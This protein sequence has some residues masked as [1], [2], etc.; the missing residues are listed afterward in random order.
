MKLKSNLPQYLRCSTLE[1]GLAVAQM[2]KAQGWKLY[3]NCDVTLLDE[4]RPFVF[5]IK[6]TVLRLG[7][8][9]RV[10]RQSEILSD[11]HTSPIVY[12]LKEA[13]DLL[14]ELSIKVGQYEVKEAIGGIEVGCVFVDWKTVKKI[15]ELAPKT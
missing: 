9:K 8:N 12:S 13:Y 5:E 6:G 11:Y 3:S 4:S 10:S 7:E 2:L 1:L 15:A 14:F